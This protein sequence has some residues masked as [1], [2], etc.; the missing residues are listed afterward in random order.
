MRPRALGA[1]CSNCSAARRN[2][3]WIPGPIWRPP[4][5]SG[6]RHWPALWAR[7]W[8]WRRPTPMP[9]AR[10]GLA[11]APA[12]AP[13][14]GPG[15]AAPRR[16]VSDVAA[17]YFEG[18]TCP[19]AS[20]GNHRDGKPGKLQIVCGLLTAADGCPVAL[21]AFANPRAAPICVRHSQ[22]RWTDN[23]AQLSGQT[24]CGVG[25]SRKLWWSEISATTR[26]ATLLHRLNT[27]V[28]PARN[29]RSTK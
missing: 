19:L 3:N 18:R 6:R 5:G 1:R 20:L 12:G 26:V 17:P 27:L 24:P 15:A 25:A 28:A 13:R 29:G 16:G 2:G 9:S 22:A 21:E 7:C 23:T 11:P 14:G 8:G 10:H 4:G